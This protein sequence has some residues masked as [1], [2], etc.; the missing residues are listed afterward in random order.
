[1]AKPALL[2]QAEAGS[3]R[4]YLQFGG[5]G[6]PWYKELSKYYAEPAFKKFFDAALNAID[7]ERPRVEG[8]VGLPH[9]IDARGWLEDESKIPSEDYLG[10]AAVSIPMIQMTQLAHVE[11]LIQNEFPLSEMI[12]Y[13]IGA[14]GHSQ[15]LIP[16]C[17]M[18]MNRSGDDYYEAVAKYVKYLLN[19]GVSAQ[20]AYPQFDPT[21]DE[22][23]ESESL[24][25]TA[26]APMV[27][28][29]G[30]DHA[31]MER[32]VQEINSE[33]GDDKKIYI[34]LYNTP[35]NRIL[36]SH[37]SSLVAFHKKYK[38][39]IDEKKLKFVYLRT[40]C[41]FHCAMMEPVR[42]IFEPEIKRI[43][44][45][46]KGSDLQIPV[47]SFYDKA[48]MKTAGA[49]LPIKMYVDMAIQ[50]L[51][52]DKSMQPV[53]DNK[54]ITHI[55]DFGPGKTSQRLSMETLAALGSETPV[56]AAAVPKD[57]KSIL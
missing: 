45:D 24:G 21:T 18:A 48:D 40:T 33:L 6:A 17:L 56:L 50:T 22:I 15:G 44:F 9:G 28:V 38:Q 26:P 52:W 43:G 27:A 42:E 29:L 4:L 53:A 37:R 11:N 54:D 20:K 8:T 57:L 39:D 31:G 25:G 49:D 1:M 47:Y 3:A 5:Q 7:E 23:A 41:P 19:L 12:K 36:S 46:Y 14:T 34:S 16:A 32:R 51:Y 13:S 55:L 10:C 35:A 30:E 2:Q